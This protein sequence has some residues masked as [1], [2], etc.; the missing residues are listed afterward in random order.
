MPASAHATATAME[1]RAPA[2][3]ASAA[4]HRAVFPVGEQEVDETDNKRHEDRDGGRYCHGIDTSRYDPNQNNEW[5][6]EVAVLQQVDPGGK[7]VE[8]DAL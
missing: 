7:F 2:A 6:D 3:K 1:L 4:V 5:N 8:G